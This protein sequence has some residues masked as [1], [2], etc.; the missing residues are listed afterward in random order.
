MSA[1]RAEPIG[2]DFDPSATGASPADLRRLAEGLDAAGF[3]EDAVIRV[4]GAPSTEHLL[5]NTAMYAYFV[6]DEDLY[7]SVEGLLTLIFVLNKAVPPE[8]VRNAISDELFA[9]LT[10]LGLLVRSRRGWRATVSITPFQ[11]RY[12]LSDQLFR[13]DGHQQVTVNDSVDLV[14]PPHATSLLA[15]RTLGHPSESLLDVGCGSGFLALARAGTATRVSGVDIS[16]RCVRFAQVNAALNNL[17]GTFIVADFASL[18]LPESE[19]FGSLV[20]NTPTRPRIGT[21][22]SELGQTSAQ[23]VVT[24]AAAAA[25]RLLRPAGTAHVLISVELPRGFASVADAVTHWLAGDPAAEKITE[26]SVAE[27]DAPLLTITDEQLQ[28]RRLHGQSLLVSS[29]AEAE[30]LISNLIERDV[31]SVVPAMVRIRV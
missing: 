13:S 22:D 15:L 10:R 16:P 9:V 17:P 4:T 20:F 25:A 29:T 30:L 11:S 19:R 1:V 28:K 21:Q 27:V 8:P 6:K 7:S 23:R 31:V 24:L 2:L 14:M 12:F 3:R 18:S 5:S 26:L